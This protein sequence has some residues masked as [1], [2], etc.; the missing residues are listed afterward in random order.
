MPKG[1]VV[2]LAKII[3]AVPGNQSVSSECEHM[4]INMHISLLV[5]H[6][7]RL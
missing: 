5:A 7:H 6:Q 2:F 4:Y 3:S 1:S